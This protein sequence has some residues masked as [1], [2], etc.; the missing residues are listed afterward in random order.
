MFMEKENYE[1]RSFAQNFA[2]DVRATGADAVKG[3]TLVGYALKFDDVTTIHGR[4]SSWEERIDRR[5]LDNTD[6]S[7][8]LALIDHEM[9]KMV[10]KAGANMTLNVDDIGLEVRIELNN[11]TKAKDLY[12]D[13]T[14][15][16]Y[17]GMSFGF[18]APGQVVEEREGQL[19]LRTITE[20]NPLYEVTFTHSP[21]YPTTEVFARSLEAAAE[22]EIVAETEEVVT[23]DEVVDETPEAVE[24]TEAPVV[25]E[26]EAV[27]EVEA[28]ASEEVAEAPSADVTDVESESLAI[29]K[30][31]LEAYIATFKS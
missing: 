21:A 23:T 13:V 8:V 20:I 9:S 14:T 24:E 7:G 3:N 1:K 4:S 22:E 11:S 19:P 18:Y 31:E 26:T 28:E 15:G 6:L 2:A 25:E 10:G 12:E 5:A 17:E 16:L 29:T 30:E 27:E